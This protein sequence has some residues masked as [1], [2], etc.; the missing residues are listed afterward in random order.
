[1][2]NKDS[3]Y[4]WWWSNSGPSTEG[5]ISVSGIAVKLSEARKANQIPQLKDPLTESGWN[6][7]ILKLL[8]DFC[9]PIS[10]VKSLFWTDLLNNNN[11]MGNYGIW[12]KY[13]NEQIEIN[14]IDTRYWKI[15]PGEDA[16]FFDRCVMDQNIATGWDLLGDLKDYLS[17]FEIFKKYYMERYTEPINPKKIHSLNQLWDFINLKVGDIIIANKGM[18]KIVGLGKVTS[19]YIYKDGYDEYKHTLG[20]NWFET[21]IKDVPPE[22]KDITKGWFGVTV[23]E[24]TKEE[25]GRLNT[26][27]GA[28]ENNLKIHD[29]NNDEKI[30]LLMKKKQIIL[31]GPPGTG[32][33]YNTKSIAVDLINFKD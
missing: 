31:Y 5:P 3:L 23:K 30:I 25:Y 29:I 6:Y 9:I 26:P 20:V 13:Q 17:D 15:A 2:A 7:A 21:T 33:T 18:G 27:P 28:P 16:K 11:N 14:K 32:K 4:S 22:A 1:M 24:L 19:E 10:G 8:L 12:K